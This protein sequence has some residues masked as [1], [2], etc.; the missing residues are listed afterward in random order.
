ML[1]PFFISI[2]LFIYCHSITFVHGPKLI[3][4]CAKDNVLMALLTPQ[5][6]RRQ[7]QRRT[8]KERNETGTKKK[9]G[10]KKSLK[11]CH[12]HFEHM[13]TFVCFVSSFS[14]FLPP[15]PFHSLCPL[16]IIK[17]KSSTCEMC[18]YI[19]IDNGEYDTEK[20]SLIFIRVSKWRRTEPNAEYLERRR[21]ERN[22][23]KTHKFCPFQ[24]GNGNVAFRM[25]SDAIAAASAG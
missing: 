4:I 15:V 19:K 22:E 14:F 8:N 7:T 24:F 18:A 6:R 9:N 13:F 2:M 20:K 23:K 16:I 11:P 25:K 10:R 17:W 12:F 21:G 3:S 5:Q 1:Q